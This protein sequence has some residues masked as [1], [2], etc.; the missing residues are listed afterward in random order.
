MRRTGAALTLKSSSSW[1]L[2]VRRLYS[3]NREV[4]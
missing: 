3:E 4:A 2:L 1:E